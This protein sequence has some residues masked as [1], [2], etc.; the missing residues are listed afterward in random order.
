[1]HKDDQKINTTGVRDQFTS[2]KILSL[3]LKQL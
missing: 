3:V 1:M 2:R